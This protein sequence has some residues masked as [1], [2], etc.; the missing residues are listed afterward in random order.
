MAAL[1]E[2]VNL[3]GNFGRLIPGQHGSDRPGGLCVVVRS[4]KERRRCFRRHHLRKAQRSG[5]DEYL[6]IRPR[7]C[8]LDRIPGFVIS[9]DGWIGDERRNLTTGR[10]AHDADARRV[11]LPF[12]RPGSHRAHGAANVFSGVVD[13]V[14]RAGFEEQP[15]LQRECSDSQACEILRGLHAFVIEHQLTMST[16]RR[17]DD[18]SSIPLAGRRQEHGERRIV[19]V[20][21]PPVLVLLGFRAPRLE[22][23]RA[24]VPQ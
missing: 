8:A 24:L 5:I 20:L 15:V 6:E 13:G 21:V 16:A 3:D 11:H 18:R 14:L 19:D 22:A 9:R 23:G 10:P 17:N 4:H 12:R 1:G 7:T 2:Q